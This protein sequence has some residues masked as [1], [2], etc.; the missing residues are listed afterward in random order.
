MKDVTKERTFRIELLVEHFE[1]E[2]PE[3]M[4]KIFVVAR[5]TWPRVTDRTLMSYAASAFHIL[6]EKNMESELHE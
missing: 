3:F 6:R 4:D 5:K 2:P 1:K